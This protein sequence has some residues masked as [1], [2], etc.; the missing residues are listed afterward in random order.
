MCAA[1]R[2]SPDAYDTNPQISPHFEATPALTPLHPEYHYS[3]NAASIRSECSALYRIHNLPL[4]QYYA[5]YYAGTRRELADLDRD[6]TIVM[7]LELA[8][9]D[10]RRGRWMDLENEAR[11]ML[12]RWRL[13][14]RHGVCLRFYR[15][16]TPSAVSSSSGRMGEREAIYEA[17]PVNPALSH[18]PRPPH[19]HVPDGYPRNRQDAPRLQHDYGSDV[20]FGVGEMREVSMAEYSS[21]MARTPTRS[22]PPV[23]IP[24]FQQALRRAQR[25]YGSDVDFGIGETRLTTTA[26]LSDSEDSE[27]DIDDLPPVEPARVPI[28]PPPIVPIA[29][30]DYPTDHPSYFPHP[31]SARPQLIPDTGSDSDSD[32]PDEAPTP[33]P[34]PGVAEPIIRDLLD[35][36]TP[37]APWE[38]ITAPRSPAA[39][40]RPRP[41]PSVPANV[42][43]LDSPWIAPHWGPLADDPA[44]VIPGRVRRAWV[45]G[46]A[47]DAGEIVSLLP[48]PGARTSGDRGRIDSATAEAEHASDGWE[49][50]SEDEVTRRRRE[51]EDHRRV[52]GRASGAFAPSRRP[53]VPP[54]AVKLA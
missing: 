24:R 49:V 31:S 43:S 4:P 42:I 16:R 38:V 7:V 32:T 46:V 34:E 47:D 26:D 21:E 2:P 13:D 19:V 51:L 15:G 6:R 29:P 44:L 28:Y 1:P 20:D 3:T 11:A 14:G 45:E 39:P 52:Q 17:A 48:S 53:G 30:W 54:A 37:L 33:Q 41:V 40:A 12:W 27:T 35:A 23:E 36:T 10:I 22:R 18:G 5:L 50:A 8:A 25:D 9:M